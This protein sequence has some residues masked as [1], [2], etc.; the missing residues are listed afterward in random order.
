MP[1]TVSP[2]P[3]SRTREFWNRLSE[4]MELNQLWSE[5]RRDARSSYRFY[6]KDMAAA[7]AAGVPKWQGVVHHARQFFWA[8]MM[9][10]TPA[11]RVL[12]LVA[13]VLLILPQGNIH[14]RE[15]DLSWGG[16]PYF[17]GLL[18]LVVLLLEVSDRVLMKRDLEIARDIQQWL[19]PRETPH[20]PGVDIAF[21]TRPQ[22]TVAGDYY[23]VLPLPAASAGGMLL[24]VADVAG[25][26]IPAALLMAT[27]QAS[28]R[29]L[30]PTVDSLRSL[31]LGVNRYT[32][33]NNRGGP[34]F[35]TAFLA[36]YDPASRTLTYIN[37]GH[38]PPVVLRAGGLERLEAGG[39]PLGILAEA[40][41]ESG[42]VT[43][44]PG[45]VVFVFTDGVVEAV[46]DRE[47]EYGE[48]R[49]LPLLA[50]LRA[51]SGSMIV[52]RVMASVDAFAAGA[53]QYDDITCLAVKVV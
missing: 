11:R 41:Y 48:A 4:G 16:A 21:T 13:L 36:A 25:K 1:A 34:R 39:I 19:V 28:V 24:V 44:N 10:L 51:E 22:N 6:S 40:T 37:A 3:T 31:V 12:L 8:V 42:S 5:F 32:C 26:S 30:A 29:T 27:L 23:D 17:G 43:L 49:L 50:A 52:S 46:N 45:D 20:I 53:R 9:K 33:E 2:P 38:N 15:T 14:T 7:E 18:L 35:T 47:E